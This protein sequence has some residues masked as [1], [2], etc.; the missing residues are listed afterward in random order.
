MD[1][2]LD[3]ETDSL[4][5]NVIHCIVA[6]ERESGKFHIWKE[7]ECY[8]YFPLFAKRVNKFIMHNGI[9][10]D[11]P[12]L[13]RLTGTRIRLSQIEDT[14]ILSQLTDPVREDGH[15]LQSWGNRFDFHKMEFK[16]FTHLSDEMIIY[17]KRDVDITERVWI[18][19]QEDIKNIDRRS[20]D[21]EYTIRLLVSKQERNGFTLNLEKA[22]GLNA[23]LQDKSDQLEKEVQESFTPRPI[24]IKEINPRYK[25]DGSLSL[26]GLKHI[27]DPSTVAGPH[28]SI[29]YQTFNLSS[30]QQIV[31]RLI[32][33]GWEPQKFT[34]KGHAIVDEGVL[35]DV[36]IPEAQMIADYLTLKKRIAQVKSWV[37]AVDKDGKVHGQ[38]LTLRAISGRMAHHSPNMAQVPASYSLYGKDCRECWT[39]GDASNILVGCDAS[40]L[41]LRALAHYLN[42]SKFTNEVVDGDIHTANQ[43]AA[44]LETRD[45]AKTFIYAFIYGA[46]AAKIGSVVGGTAQD[47]Q[48]LIDTFLSNVPALAV[49]RERVDKASQRGYLVGLDGRHL[50][51]R[52]QHAAVNLLIQ[53]AGAVICKQW[54]VD[55][56]IL[57]RKN[58]LN[59]KLVASI[60][61]E[62]QHEVLKTHA[63]IFGELT[64]Q[65]MKE[66]ERKLKIKCP[67]DSEYKIG[68]NW[69]ETH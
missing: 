32:K 53:G 22:M 15:S 20:I 11:A 27:K 43:Q 46:G 7:E 17:C 63:K 60:H 65:A 52:N 5:A 16:N 34:E 36:N 69:S 58:K 33:C 30:R 31:S 18:S 37:D 59:Y 66:T 68:Q 12:V 21:L 49:L 47:G 67:L 41:E 24:P 39:V 51:V 19:L 14:M 62:Y 42:D 57:A 64:K 13:N 50:K 26:V 23:K 45:Q 10:F 6:K 9:S 8:K 54:L 29:D 28:T 61:D 25:K 56:D 55:I 4:D 48:R 3:I 35:R 1:V 2:V 44:G 40:S 38:V